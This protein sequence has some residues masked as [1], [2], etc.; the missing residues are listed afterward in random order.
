MVI[1]LGA[2]AAPILQFIARGSSNRNAIVCH[3]SLTEERPFGAKTEFFYA[4]IA[5]EIMCS[6]LIM[7]YA[8]HLRSRQG[9]VNT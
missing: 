3:P 7:N 9:M 1:S 6:K 5:I 4:G 2:Q 8:L